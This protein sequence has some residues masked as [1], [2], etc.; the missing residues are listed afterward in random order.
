M[1]DIFMNTD[2][3]HFYYVTVWTWVGQ[4][5]VHKLRGYIFDNH[6][7]FQILPKIYKLPISNNYMRMHAHQARW[8]S[9]MT[10]YALSKNCLF[11]AHACDVKYCFIE[12]YP[13]DVLEIRRGVAIY[14]MRAALQIHVHAFCI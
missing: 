14:L 6:R 13:K 3:N 8:Q 1:L 5:R 2:C 12:N 11:T 10:F 7:Q 4:N 9:Q